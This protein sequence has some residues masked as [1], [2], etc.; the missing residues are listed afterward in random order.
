MIDQETVQ[1]AFTK[2]QNA[3]GQ[4][5]DGDYRK[6]AFQVV[7]SKMLEATQS[8]GLVP[9]DMQAAPSRDLT[10]GLTVQRV[11]VGEF[12]SI[13][14]PASYVERVT[15]IAYHALHG[16]QQESVTRQE[17]L[18]AFRKARLTPPKN[19]SDVI[20]QCIRRGL[21]MDASDS[22]EGQKAWTITQTGER[23]VEERLVA[24]A[25]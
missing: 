23:L 2:A 15:A 18:A 8:V 3:V 21:L 13:L 16:Q 1:D 24:V 6:I 12:L 5:P 20:A 9:R 19:I 7:F 22:K 17:F 10:A 4:I 11:A 14:N 25:P